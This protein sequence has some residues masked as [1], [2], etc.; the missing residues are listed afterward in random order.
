[1]YNFGP[2]GLEFDPPATIRIPLAPNA[3]S[4]SQYIVYW[5]D[6]TI[7]PNGAWT[8]DGIHNPAT[9]SSDGTYLEVQ[10]DHF[11]VFQPGG[12]SVVSGG[13]GGGGCAISPN[14]QGNVIEYMLPYVFYVVVLLIIKRKD[15]RNRKTT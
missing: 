7:L 2:S 1:M 10:V 9:K 14:G 13:G 11:S 12:V 15:A 3:P 5:W 8:T 6:S 4:Y